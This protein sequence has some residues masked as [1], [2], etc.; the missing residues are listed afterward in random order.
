MK[1]GKNSKKAGTNSLAGYLRKNYE[2][3]LFLI[4]GLVFLILFEALPMY[5][6]TIAFKNF[7]VPLGLSGSPWVGF[8]N[9]KRIF[10]DPYFYKVIR[11]TL[12]INL[13]KVIFITPLPMLL[14]VLMN[15]MQIVKIKKFVQTIVYV[16]HFFT[17]VVVYSVFYIIF[18]SGGVVNTI[19]KILGGDQ[20]LFFMNGGWFRF[21]LVLSDAWH[22]TGWGTIVYLAV[23]TSIDTNIYEAAI[24]DGA[25]KFRQ[26]WHITLP[27]L[28]PTFVLM[29]SIN[30]GNILQSGFGQVL[31]FYNPTVYEMGDIIGTY[32]Y[33]VGLG[34]TNY[35]YATAVGLFNSVI[36]FILVILSNMF[37]R[38]VTGKTI[39]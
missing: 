31:V 13:Y 36:G 10:N 20:I 32:V 4:P 19:I 35:S 24:V 33:R 30:L 39:W 9:F 6:I 11:N 12:V 2:F 27:S 17:W 5:N 26:M 25:N 18:G 3:Y 7:K 37:S 28:L 1:A 38:R 29:I 8:N 15:E 14:A 34:Q 21:L 22:S 16:P 23:I